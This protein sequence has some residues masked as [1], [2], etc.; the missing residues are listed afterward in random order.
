MKVSRAER[1]YAASL[2]KV[3]EQVGHIINGFPAGDMS[4]VPTLSQIL[5]RYAEALIPWA[6]ATASRML[7]EVNQQDIAAWRRMSESMGAELQ[8]EILTAP[9]GEAMRQLMNEQVSLITSIPIEA[10]Q[11]VH[12][13]TI[14]AMENSGRAS[15]LI[16]EIMRS[17]EVAASRARTIARTETTR[18]ASNLT[19]ARAKHVGSPGY[20]WR[21]AKD[22]DVRKSHRK[23]AGQFVPWDQPPTLDGLTGHA[24]CLPNCRCYPEAVIPED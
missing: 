19:Q 7:A 22:G 9:T 13:L 5:R 8:R 3:A 16:E 14:K 1:M 15:S 20:I 2:T 11:R 21:T 18:A 24:G 4:A 23:M 12:D 10:A 17:G 6:E